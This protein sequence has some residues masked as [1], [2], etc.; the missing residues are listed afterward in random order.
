M[1][2]INTNIILVLL[3]FCA[4]FLSAQEAQI[5]YPEPILS[6]ILSEE[7][8][9]VFPKFRNELDTIPC[10]FVVHA[11][12]SFVIY[13][14]TGTLMEGTYS[15][16]EFMGTWLRLEKNHLFGIADLSAQAILPCEYEQISII[17]REVLLLE[18]GANR[19][20]FLP[21]SRK[22]FDI[23]TLNPEFLEFENPIINP[24][25]FADES[26]TV[27]YV[28]LT[29]YV[30]RRFSVISLSG[31]QT[32]VYDHIQIANN[33][34]YCV[35]Q[36]N[37]KLGYIDV[38]QGK[39]IIPCIYET[40]R[41]FDKSYFFYIHDWLAEVSLNDDYF[42][43]GTDGKRWWSFDDISISKQI[44]GKWGVTKLIDEEED[45]T[46][47]EAIIIPYE[48]DK[49][50]Y[51]W[52]DFFDYH[53]IATMKGKVGI[54]DS[55][56]IQLIPIEYDK[57]YLTSDL[58]DEYGPFYILEKDKKKGLAWA[59]GEII[60]PCLYDEIHPL[61]EF[62][63][64]DFSGVIVSNG[65][66]LG[67]AKFNGKEL[68]PPVYSSLNSTY[69]YRLDNKEVFL[70]KKDGKY[71]YMAVTADTAYT[72]LPAEYNNAQDEIWD[73]PLFIIGKNK[74][75]GFFDVETNRLIEPV[76]DWVDQF[77]YNR[78]PVMLAKK[79]GYINSKGEKI[80]PLEYD[81]CQPFD[82]DFAAVEKNKKWA[83]VDT[84][85][86][87]ITEFKYDE[88]FLFVNQ[89]AIVGLNGVYGFINNK[90]IETIKP[91]YKGCRFFSN[92][93]ALA[94][95]DGKSY[96]YL[97]EEGKF[98]IEPVYGK[99]ND[100]KDNYAI[101][102]KNKKWGMIDTTGKEIIPIQYDQEFYFSFEYGARVRL[103]KKAGLIDLKNGIEI[104][105][106]YDDIG[107]FGDGLCSVKKGK[108]YGFINARNEIVIPCKYTSVT[109]FSNG[110][111]YVTE[112]KKSYYINPDG[113]ER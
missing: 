27:G 34:P 30:A 11:D 62:L 56:N 60:F 67:I 68:I 104:P 108:Y 66:N 28:F 96:G 36:K 88:A 73:S 9:E 40:A 17:G 75:Y 91:Q 101:V 22:K 38:I 48:Y 42:K 33:S 8:I 94:T 97:D 1:S 111:A 78:A 98:A 110:S 55:R 5:T 63:E 109:N 90:G 89:Y 71:G 46:P 70:A 99:S 14:S 72:I 18:E 100:F 87:F 51:C 26:R 15:G 25:G 106:M 93:R 52:E 112:G 24:Q 47:I 19:F 31:N 86:K 83:Y 37:E 76:Y 54:I 65:K 64:V 82:Y 21:E 113:S 102:T 95:L 69:Y 45:G 50:E 103:N 7:P 13:S 43:I 6:R 3:L 81:Y 10:C 85:G 57:L 39:E 16:V 12:S 2:P 35:V 49:L 58:N 20:V 41:D 84:T 80:L 59:N 23:G 29:D 61:W 107:W 32:D 4:S 79:Y 105:C 53:L 77:A 74:K 92:G 44:P